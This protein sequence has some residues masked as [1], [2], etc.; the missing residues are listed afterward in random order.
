MIS[1]ELKSQFAKI[2]VLG[3]GSDRVSLSASEIAWL[4]FLAANDLGLS[5]YNAAF[6]GMKKRIP[7]F[8]N[9]KI[10]PALPKEWEILTTDELLIELVSRSV[11]PIYYSAITLPV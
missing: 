2:R 9:S 11:F 1:T 8:F 7:S 6:K 4:L 10:P 5:L 3:Q